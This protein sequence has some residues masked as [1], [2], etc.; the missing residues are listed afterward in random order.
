MTMEQIEKTAAT[1]R[2]TCVSKVNA[3]MDTVLAIQKGEFPDDRSLKCYTHC[4]MKTIR[5]YKNGRV[6]EGMMLKQLDLMMPADIAV[7]MKETTKICAAEPPTGD[8]CETTFNF[9]KCSYNNDPDHFFF[10]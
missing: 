9:V 10:P 2:N 5:T 6:D 1:L 7:L 4:I 3:N 8:D